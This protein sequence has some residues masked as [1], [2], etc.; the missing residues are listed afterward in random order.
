MYIPCVYPYILDVLHADILVYMY[1]FIAR[2]LII[3]RARFILC[4][5]SYI[6]FFATHIVFLITIYIIHPFNPYILTII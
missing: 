3:D 4:I 2:M 1:I 6:R 5:P